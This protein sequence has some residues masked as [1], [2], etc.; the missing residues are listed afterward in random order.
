[1]T[2]LQEKAQGKAKQAVGQ[3]VGNDKLV[4]EGKKQER[5]A[6][7]ASGQQAPSKEKDRAKNVQKGVAQKPGSAEETVEPTGRKGPVLE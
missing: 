3:I 2:K 5:H 1:M 4:V 6:D 7:Q